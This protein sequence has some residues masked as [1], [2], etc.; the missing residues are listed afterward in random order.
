MADE[1]K[2]GGQAFP[3]A[4]GNPEQGGDYIPGMTLRDRFAGDA[5]PQAVADYNR[6]ESAPHRKGERVLPYAAQG[7]GTREDIIA[8]QAYRYADAMLQARQKGGDA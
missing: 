3:A 6:T 1:R 8:R 4:W 7:T 2:D 5:L